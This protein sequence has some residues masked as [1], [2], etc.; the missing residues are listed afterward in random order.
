MSDEEEQYED[1]LESVMGGYDEHSETYGENEYNMIKN[2][3]E[4]FTVGD[5]LM[6]GAKL[7]HFIV[8]AE[9]EFPDQSCALVRMQSPKLHGWVRDG[10]LSWAQE[11]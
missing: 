1:D 3:L 11:C 2:L 7:N 6:E 4:R 10:M 8:V 9:W 5:E